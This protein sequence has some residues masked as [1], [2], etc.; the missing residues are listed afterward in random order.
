[1]Q[2]DSPCAVTSTIAYPP[3][4]EPHRFLSRAL[5]WARWA[6]IAALLLITFM[7]PVADNAR[8]PMWMLVLFFAGYTLL[9]DGVRRWIP[10][11][12]S[13]A[14]RAAL[15][16][17]VAAVLYFLAAE[18]GGPLFVL[19]ILAVD[20]AAASLSLRGTLLYTAAVCAV[21][22]AIDLTLPLWTQNPMDV[23]ALGTRLVMLALVGGGMALITRRLVLEHE[24]TR[25]VRGEAERLEELDRVRA[26]FLSSV[27]HDLR[28][29]LT[30][31][32]AG[33]GLLEAST[34]GR[35]R[36]D[37][38]DLLGN[39]R[40]NTER[41]S[42]LIDDLLAFNQLEAGILSLDPEPLDLREVV[43]SAVAALQYV[44]QIKGQALDALLPEPL[45]TVGDRRRLEQVVLNVLGNAHYHTPA[46]TRITILGETRNDEVRLTVRDNGPGIPPN[47][48]TTIFQRF[49]RLGS[50]DS[51]S[52]LG[53]AI[54]KALV[55]L[56]GGRLWAES[57]PEPGAVFHIA[58]P[59]HLK[60]DAR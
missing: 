31:A 47:E 19:F 18:H 33:L 21:A 3:P 26:I 11:F 30:A 24:A 7:Q 16:L 51:G 28:T 46:G 2:R 17:P 35:L 50:T 27:S 39:A 44:I 32:R 37:E 48:L 57:Y 49:Y 8:F 41:L 40:R 34:D 20:C 43:R 25:T 4:Q 23:R 6:T 52:G 22:A 12:L 38:H 5:A 10:A 14:Q 42:L 1:M 53:L 54:A 58:L 29:P 9:L 56:H 13:L 60:E 55:E 36:P 59:L 15:D 45:P